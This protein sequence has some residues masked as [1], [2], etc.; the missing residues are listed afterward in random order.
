ME[1]GTYNPSFDGNARQDRAGHRGVTPRACLDAVRITARGRL[2]DAS[3][4]RTDLSGSTWF[5]AT[6]GSTS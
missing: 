5:G 3:L 6:P 1:V 2:E 4:A